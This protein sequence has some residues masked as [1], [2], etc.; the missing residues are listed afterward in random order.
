MSN[1][2]ADSDSSVIKRVNPLSVLQDKE[3][4]VC[5]INRHPIGLFTMYTIGGGLLLL[6]AVLSFVLVPHLVASLSVVGLASFFIIG[7]LFLASRI[8]WDNYWVVTS[9]SISQMSR[10]SLFDKE[11]CQLSFSHLEDVAAHQE[12][13]WAHMFHYGT[14]SAETAGATDKFTMNFCPDPT[15]YAQKILA[16]R[17]KFEQ[18]L[19]PKDD[20]SDN[21]DSNIVSYNVPLDDE[22]DETD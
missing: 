11:A 19:H 15:G 14:I 4:M 22:S 2:S 9:D 12:G 21:D 6:I 3:D 10:T 20:D 5:E 8:Y 17:E 18:G 1:S 13:M 7:F 16:A